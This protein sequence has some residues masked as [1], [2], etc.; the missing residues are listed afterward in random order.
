MIPRAFAD[1][2]TLMVLTDAAVLQGRDMIEQALAA[3]RGG[4]TAIQLRDKTG[5]TRELFEQAQALIEAVRP[6]GSLVIVNDRVDVAL[7]AEADGAHLGDDDLP[8]AAARG[9]APAGFILGRSAANPEEA[10]R[11]ERDGADYL[12]VGPVFAT[13]SKPDAG[14]AI[15]PVRIRAVTTATPLPVVAI[16]GIDVSN[17]SVP[18]EAGAVGVAV[19]RAVTATAD[20]ESAARDLLVVV[21]RAREASSRRFG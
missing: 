2:L 5:T 14:D 21:S 8:L 10:I 11:A 9:I 20:A 7:A 3:V 19:I 4:A 6:R 17:A 12:G 18:I 13:L 1:R 16:G 15:G